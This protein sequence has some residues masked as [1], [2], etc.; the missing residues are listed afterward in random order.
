M[1]QRLR[2]ILLAALLCQ[3]LLAYAVSGGGE[4]GEGGG[5]PANPYVA[6][7]KPLV[8][9]IMDGT[10]TRFLQVDPVFAVGDPADAALI[11]KYMPPLLH[12]LNVYF[13]SLSSEEII[14]REGKQKTLEGARALVNEVL[15]KYTGH[16]PVTAVYVRSFVMQ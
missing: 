13:S 7:P 9:N 8:V 2:A 16:E 1:A 3:P 6:L 4:G 10:Q 15:K 12:E 11:T 5:A 14:T